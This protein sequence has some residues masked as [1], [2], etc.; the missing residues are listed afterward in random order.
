[1]AEASVL[2]DP[3]LQIHQNSFLSPSVILKRGII[4]V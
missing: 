4:I 3:S 1:L 2:H